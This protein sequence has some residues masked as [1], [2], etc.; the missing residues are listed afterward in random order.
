MIIDDID[1]IIKEELP[2]SLLTE[3]QI[4]IVKK[5]NFRGNAIKYIKENA[6]LSLKESAW[7]YDFYINN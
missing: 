3:E 5:I 4:E 6:G 2:K 7:Y 1:K